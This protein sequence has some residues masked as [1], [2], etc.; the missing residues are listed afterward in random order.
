M[1]EQAAELAV[2]GL[3]HS[4]VEIR[5]RALKNILCKLDHS[6]ISVSDIV[7]EKMLF[8]LLLE[9]F[10]FPEVP[11]QEEVLELLSTLSKHPSAA[12]MLRDVG[13]VDFL[14]QL[15]RNVEPSL[16]AVIDGTLDQLFLLP[17]LLPSHNTVSTHRQRNTTPT[18]TDVPPE[19][20][21]PKMGYFHKSMPSHTDVAPQKIAVHESVRC[22]KFSVFPWLTLTNTDRHILSSN[23]SSL[24][25]SNPTL[26]R[27]TCELL[28]DV[29]MQDFPAEI[30]LQ[31]PSIV[32]VSIHDH[33]PVL[34]IVFLMF[35]YTHVV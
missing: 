33:V 14:S 18:P 5:V 27:T 16:R 19:D 30:F 1:P 22:L 34:T 17:P 8:V 12:Q 25:S 35:G 13:A 9:W 3:G 15:S 28:C 31:R 7:Q 2:L 10:N 6:L 24:R 11:M 32:Q 23:E 21:C 4:L 20:H 26:V 29:I